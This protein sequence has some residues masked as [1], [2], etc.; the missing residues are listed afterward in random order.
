M[1][2]DDL[3]MMQHII[4]NVDVFGD[5]G[6][7]FGPKLTM[8]WPSIIDGGPIYPWTVDHRDGLGGMMAAHQGPEWKT[9][10]LEQ[11]M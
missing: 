9:E 1:L 3:T 8:Q 10:E 5:H 4:Q 11:F 7:V 2:D 6:E